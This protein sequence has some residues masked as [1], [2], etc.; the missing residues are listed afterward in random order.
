VILICG[1]CDRS[2]RPGEPY[3]HH[4]KISNSAGGITVHVH[5]ECPPDRR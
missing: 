4:D 1:R 3:T 2:I 5:L